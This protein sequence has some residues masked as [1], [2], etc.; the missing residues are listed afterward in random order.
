MHSLDLKKA[1][2]WVPAPVLLISAAA[3]G[4]RNLMIAT[5]GMQYLDP[6][7]GSLAIGVARHSVTGRLIDESGEFAINVLA[8]SQTDVLQRARESVRLPSDQVDKFEAM[9]V[10]TFQGDVTGAPLVKGCV[11]NLECRVIR[12]LDGGDDYYMVVGD[13]VGLRGVPDAVPMV[14]FRQTSYGVRAGSAPA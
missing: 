2:Y 8:A 14:M 11:A 13:I 4:R 9:G 7:R 3:G 12:K 1:L 5:R 6:P 10:E